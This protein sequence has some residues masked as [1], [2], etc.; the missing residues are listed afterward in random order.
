MA[1]DQFN[2]SLLYKIVTHG[3]D[4]DADPAVICVRHIKLIHAWGIDMQAGVMTDL[5]LTD[6]VLHNAHNV[7]N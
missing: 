7:I 6:M 3:A 1:I 4:Q 2:L 5:S